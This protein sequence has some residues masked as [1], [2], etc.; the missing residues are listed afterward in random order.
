MQIIMNRKRSINQRISIKLVISVLVYVT[1]LLLII[2][3]FDNTNFYD[4]RVSNE[5]TGKTK[6]GIDIKD[7]K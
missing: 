4:H 6:S 2:K 7:K 1:V 5:L 3:L